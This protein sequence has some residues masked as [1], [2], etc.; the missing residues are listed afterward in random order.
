M[1]T[2]Q[3]A[4]LETAIDAARQAGRA[5][6]DAASRDIEVIEEMPGDIKLVM[7]QRAEEIIVRT[8]LGR[9]P[10]HRILA[11]ERG[12]DGGSGAVRW[13]IDPLDGT[14]NY[15]RRL[16]NWCTCVAATRE[17]EP[18]VGVVY[19]PLR[20][21]MFWAQRGGGAFLNGEPIHV[22]ERHAVEG[23]LF[24]Y[25]VYHRQPASVEAWLHRAPM[26]TPLARSTRNVGS[27]GLHVA[28]VA[29]GMVDAFFEYGV[30]PWDVSAGTV[31]VRE[32][33]GKVSSWPAADGALDYV[34]ASAGL[35][36]ALLDLEF[37]PWRGPG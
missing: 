5:L 35:H 12:E 6:L 23:S 27:A 32:A 11:E 3:D 36:D 20:D 22:N 19:D 16:P 24:A 33:G 37:W 15:A 31:L 17:D 21:Q 2:E 28:Y 4:V 14:T 10:D 8:V 13:V 30:F 25:G 7:D 18:F 9:F 26:L 1:S 29:A 34:A